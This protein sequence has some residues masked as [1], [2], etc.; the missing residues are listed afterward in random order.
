MLVMNDGT[1][2]LI[3]AGLSCRELVRRMSL[4]GVEPS[5]IEAVVLTHEHTDH[6]RGADK[7]GSTYGVPVHGTKS[8][9]ALSSLDGVKTQTFAN[10]RPFSVGPI[11][12]RPFKVRHLAA[13]PVAF[14]ATV[15]ARRVGIASDLG[16]VTP[17]VI[18]EMTDADMLFVEANYDKEMLLEGNYPGFLKR[19]IMG[20]HGHLSNDDAGRLSSKASTSR[21]KSIV[22]V[23]LSMEN[24][25]PD[26]ARGAVERS[27]ER[28]RHASE[29]VVSEHGT[30]SGPYSLA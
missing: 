21:T 17:S 28:S 30:A 4:F 15:N 9:L 19:A 2:I 11:D 24:N 25:T 5:Q 3:D 13:D 1:G 7:F 8:T 20:D 22:L 12:L 18:D 10:N 23:H 29:I 6:V 14:S 16:C 26:K 27:M